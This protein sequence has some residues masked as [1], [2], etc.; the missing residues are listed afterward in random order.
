MSAELETY[1]GQVSSIVEPEKLLRYAASFLRQS[2]ACG[3]R[4]GRFDRATESCAPGGDPLRTEEIRAAL[5][6]RSIPDRPECAALELGVEERHAELFVLDRASGN[7]FRAEEISRARKL[8]EIAAAELRRRRVDRDR[9]IVERT[10]DQLLRRLHG[11]DLHYRILHALRDLAHYDHSAAIFVFSPG[12]AAFRMQAEQIAWAKAKS[13]RIGA[14]LPGESDHALF[15]DGAN[16]PRL[17]RW[18]ASEEA[19]QENG[20]EEALPVAPLWLPFL[21]HHAADA[22]RPLARSAV[23]TPLVYESQ[24]V[25]LLALFGLHPASLGRE[26]AL[27]LQPLAP[28]AATAIHNQMVDQGVAAQVLAAGRKHAFADMARSVAHD[29]NNALGVLL[30]RTEM[31]REALDALPTASPRMRDDAL[32]IERTARMCSRIFQGLLH[33]ARRSAEP[34][35]RVDLARVLQDVLRWYG[36]VLESSGVRWRLN[37]EPRVPP[38]HA[39]PEPLERV[40]HNLLE[41]A[42]QAC[43]RGGRIRISLSARDGAA[44]VVVADDGHGIAPEV[45]PR[46]FEPFY[47]TRP[48]GHGLGLAVSR[49]IVVDLGGT[50]RLSSRPGVGT[51]AVVRLPFAREQQTPENA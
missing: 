4:R 38:V 33:F 21:D 28:L 25:G 30:P 44:R 51:L 10:Y 26:T 18:R 19:W 20:G 47:S 9:R 37:L 15:R 41:N 24:T 3:V 8:L 13:A 39:S 34:A 2:L 42:R 29:V 1:R 5:E 32:E 49:S 27:A 22:R 7:A 35:G 23:L 31:L 40:L 14:L 50:L 45:L 6:R 17:F 36:P 11:N 16:H 46:V 12:R 48:G 43:R